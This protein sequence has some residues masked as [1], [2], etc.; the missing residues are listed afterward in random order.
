MELAA[1]L[2][3]QP[4]WNPLRVTGT[5]L[6][7]NVLL[8]AKLIALCLLLTNHQARLPDEP[9]LPFLPFLDVLRA[10]FP[11]EVLV[12]GV[13][14]GSAFALLFNRRVRA[15][16][17]LLGGSILLSVVASKAYYGNNKLFCGVFLLLAGLEKPGAS[18]GLLRWQLVIVYAGAA[19]NKWFDPDWR[20][21]QFFDHWAGVR[22]ETPLY[23]AL[24][25]KLPPLVAGKIF[26]WAT[27]LTETSLAIG[28]AFRRLWPYAVWLGLLFHASAMWFT[29]STFTMFFYA[30]SASYLIFAPWPRQ[31]LTVIYDGDCGF[32]EKT[33]RFF[34]RL[35][36]DYVYRWAAFQTGVGERFGIARRALEQRAHVV[37]D[38]RVT[39]GYQ[40]FKRLV[41]FNPVC[42]FA[43]ALLLTLPGD[44][45]SAFRNWIWALTLFLFSP[46]A[47]PFGERIY[48]WI[49][50]NRHRLPGDK[51]CKVA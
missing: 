13:F 45:D 22:L 31:P 50:R 41:W 21:G 1:P 36:F 42:Y 10:P 40:A 35:D 2:E 28:F 12:K 39:S 23:L 24:A 17:L 25:S 11:F 18:P 33:R 5:E 6:A 46:L 3:S 16:A 32:C 14:F 29:G 15:S 43:M 37:A 20:S 27:I 30:M 9:F 38:G 48:D 47:N 19:L 8:A 34:E 49:A 4:S 51:T 44:G 7:P 26:C